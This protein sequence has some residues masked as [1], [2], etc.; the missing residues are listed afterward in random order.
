MDV[1]SEKI[2]QR[3]QSLGRCLQL[4]KAESEETQVGEGEG[5]VLGQG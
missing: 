5:V 3:E 1:C 2:S 4:K